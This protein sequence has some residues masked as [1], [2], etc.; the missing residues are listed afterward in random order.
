MKKL[1]PALLGIAF[2]VSGFGQTP[3]QS[4]LISETA[5]AFPEKTQL[6]VALIVNSKVIFTGVE[7][8]NDTLNYTDNSM[9]IFEIGSISKVFTSTLLA[10]LVQKQKVRL[11]DQMN[12]CV[13]LPLN[14]RDTF[15]LQELAN[16]T[17]GLP[18][19]PANLNL[20]TADFRNPY[21]NYSKDELLEYLSDD[22]ADRNSPGE[23][24]EYSN[25][26]AGLLAYLLAKKEGSD[27]ERM[28]KKYI[29][30]KYGMTHSTTEKSKLNEEL[31]PGLDAGGKETSNWDFSVLVGAGGIL[32]N[33]SDMSKFAQAQFDSANTELRLTREST[34]KVNNGMEIG[35]GW[36]IL[37]PET[38]N[39][40]HWHNGGTGGY[41]SSM[42]IDV[43]NKTAVIILSNVSAFNPNRQKIDD[44]CFGL[45]KTLK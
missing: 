6:S 3:K 17:S 25:L 45:L 29:F 24:Y 30:D 18:R 5:L 42:A 21:K 10:N 4:Q 28:L 19:L 43:E 36:H 44:L 12:S 20:A 13:D 8:H 26:G 11:N 9:K 7:C 16:H 31:V 22:S 27:Y 37:H 32:S 14:S 23:K 35:L 33:V 40:W 34:F 38:G 41:T 15:T 2:S 39:T 1:L